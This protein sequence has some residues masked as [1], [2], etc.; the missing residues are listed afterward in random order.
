[1]KKKSIII[2]L[3]MVLVLVFT[4]CG[5]EKEKQAYGPLL[6]AAKEAELYAGKLTTGFE[7]DT[8]SNSFF[9]W[10]ISDVRTETELYGK[11]A[12]AGKK[13]VVMN[14]SV[15]NTTDEEYEIGNYDF[16]SYVAPDM[17]TGLVE[18]MDSFDDAMYPDEEMLAPGKTRSGTLVFE[19]DESVEELIIDYI[20]FIGEDVYKRQYL[21]HRTD[22]SGRR[23]TGEGAVTSGSLLHVCARVH[24]F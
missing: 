6:E 2:G 24:I 1:M 5:G 13:F 11:T 3:C 4:A 18:T 14:V 15:T 12:N 20:E 16:V 23:R 9:E 19:V 10:T 21:Y 7:G 17:D 8:L 22:G